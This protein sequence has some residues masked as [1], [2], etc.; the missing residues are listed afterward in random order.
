MNIRKPVR[1]AAAALLIPILLAFT[2][3]SLTVDGVMSVI[4]P[5]ETPVPGSDLVFSD[6]PEATPE[7]MQLTYDKL[8]GV[9]NPLFA[10]T[11]GDLKVVEL[12]QLSLRAVEGNRAPAEISRTA[13]TDGLVSVTIRLQKGLLCADG[14]ELTADDL[15]FTYYVLMDESYNGPYT[16]NQ[17]PIS[18][19]PLY[20]NGMDSDMYGKYMMIY[21]EI[22]N[23][24]KYDAD[25]QKAVE[26]A[27]RAALEKGV[28]EEKLEYDPG[29]AAAQ[30]ALDEYDTVRADEIRDA[31]ED[32][33]RS[34]VQAMVE[35]TMENYSGTISLRTPYSRDEVLANT[36]LQVAYTMLDRGFGEFDEAGGFT[37]NS[38][39]HWDLV[40]SYPLS[41]D[42]YNE[43]FDAYNGDA[44]QYWSIEGFGRPDMLA[45]VQNRLVRAW[46]PQDADWRG[47]VQ[48]VSGVEKVDDR[49]I[50][51]S[52][53]FCDDAIL[54]TLTEIRVAPLH[55]YGDVSL[56]DPENGS[57][58][59]IKDDLSAV[60]AN[61][62]KAVGAGEYAYRA[63]DLRTV[64]LDANEN[65]WLGVSDIP[66]VILTKAE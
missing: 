54:R 38:G 12:T 27:K 17:L 47:G 37:A 29:V 40:T 22:Y 50:R 49:T 20:W 1:A 41:E 13:G 45:A 25:L 6:Q 24:G 4:A 7:P 10:E 30:K 9:F 42:L 59:F 39:A 64:Y 60:R 46:A 28:S 36:G 33:W 56:F 5:T 19:L 52:L 58:G 53:T 63:T 44:A 18:G 61:N 3:C 35:Y 48:T 55:V 65:Y 34:D 31:I 62:G 14:T 23:A 32:A 11:D 26:D 43:T 8:D 57:F 51:I 15:L 21:D 2:G 16:V 66:E